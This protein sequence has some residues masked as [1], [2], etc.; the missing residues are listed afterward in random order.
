MPVDDALIELM[1]RVHDAFGKDAYDNAARK[2]GA[3]AKASHPH[4]F[5]SVEE[6]TVPFVNVGAN[7]EYLVPEAVYLKALRTELQRL[8]QAH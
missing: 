6:P 4:A 3:V 5:G 2:A 7:E 1:R 8:L